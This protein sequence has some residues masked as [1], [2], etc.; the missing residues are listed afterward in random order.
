MVHVRFGKL[1]NKPQEKEFVNKREQHRRR[2]LKS[3]SIIFNNGYTK[4][5]C[6]VRNL[7]KKGAL[8]VM[9]DITGLPSDF[10]LKIG[11]EGASYNAT[12]IWKSGAQFGVCFR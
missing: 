2:V 8:L 11:D 4:F 9:S 7:N 5:D 1:Q 6:I 12:I 3:G 10:E